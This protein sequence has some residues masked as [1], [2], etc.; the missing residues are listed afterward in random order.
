MGNLFTCPKC[1]QLR[2]W[3]WKRTSVWSSISCNSVQDF[4]SASGWLAWYLDTRYTFLSIWITERLKLSKQRFDVYGF[5]QQTQYLCTFL[6][7]SWWWLVQFMDTFVSL[8]IALDKAVFYYVLHRTFCP[9]LL[10]EDTFLK[11]CCNNTWFWFS[12]DKQA[13]APLQV[14]LYGWGLF[15]P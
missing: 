15:L 11:C 2:C 12:I 9:F 13:T 3:R 4:G 10:S 7:C 1:P 14:V 5:A 8:D 6:I